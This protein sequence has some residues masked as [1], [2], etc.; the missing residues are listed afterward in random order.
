[1]VKAIVLRDPNKVMRVLASLRRL[2]DRYREDLLPTEFWT[3]GTYHPSP[4]FANA[5]L[6]VLLPDRK[7]KRVKQVALARRAARLLEERHGLV[8]DWAAGFRKSGAVWLVVKVRAMRAG[9]CRHA[10]FRPDRGD[11]AALRKLVSAVGRAPERKEE[12]VRKR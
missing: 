12:R 5:Y 10:R 2:A 8:L 7:L 11:L 3:E 1:M 6:L 4:R 9:D